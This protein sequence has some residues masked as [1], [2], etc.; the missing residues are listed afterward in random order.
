MAAIAAG[1]LQRI[2]QIVGELLDGFTE[3]EVCLEN[4]LADWQKQFEE[5]SSPQNG[6]QWNTSAAAAGETIGPPKP[7]AST[8]PASNTPQSLPLQCL[9]RPGSAAGGIESESLQGLAECLRRDDS[10]Q[11]SASNLLVMYLIRQLERLEQQREELQ[12]HCSQLEVRLAEKNQQIAQ[13][14][15][16][17]EQ[18]HRQLLQYQQ[19]CIEQ[20]QLFKP[21]WD[22]LLSAITDLPCDA[23]RIPAT[24]QP[25][26]SPPS[27]SQQILP[28]ASLRDRKASIG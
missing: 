28:L 5:F 22:S 6:G 24:E 27:H 26:E 12:T 25:M 19:H 8:S 16:Q 9:V 21:L 10:L 18:N 17:L 1:P 15:H 23:Q 7:P 2:A 3:I 13:L 11:G 4:F 14:T 20:V